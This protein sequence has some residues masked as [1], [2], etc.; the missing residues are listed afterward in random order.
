MSGL[1]LEGLACT[2]WALIPLGLSYYVWDGGGEHLGEKQVC[3][4]ALPR[5]A[6]AV[7]S[8]MRNPGAGSVAAL[9]VVL[10]ARW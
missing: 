5:A 7:W 9:R 3:L 1:K 8:L 2:A 4:Q 6:G 10:G